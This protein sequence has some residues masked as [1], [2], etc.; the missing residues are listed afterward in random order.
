MNP[1]IVAI[2]GVAILTVGIY[3]GISGIATQYA[4]DLS[5]SSASAIT[6]AT[7]TQDP[8]IHQRVT[9]RFSGLPVGSRYHWSS[10]EGEAQVSDEGDL[11]VVYAIPG[12]KAAWAFYLDNKIWRQISC[13][14][15]VR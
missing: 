5:D 13:S 12:N 7:T 9:Y 1:V 15:A 4:F 14:A 2:T 6:C 11:E 8:R 3:I 10:D